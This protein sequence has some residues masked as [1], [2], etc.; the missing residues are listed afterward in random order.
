LGLR[1]KERVRELSERERER[2][3]EAERERERNAVGRR[4]QQLRQ[5]Y[6]GIKIAK[7]SWK[8]NKEKT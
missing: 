8:A 3:R 5:W 1:D 6:W 7:M 4:E 2:D